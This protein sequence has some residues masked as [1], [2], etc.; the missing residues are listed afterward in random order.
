MP[1]QTL[2]CCEPNCQTPDFVFSESEQ[3]FFAEKGY[4]PPRRCPACRKA[5]REQRQVQ[6]V[7][8]APPGTNTP[9]SDAVVDAFRSQFKGRRSD[10]G[11]GDENR[12]NSWEQNEGR[13]GRGRQRRRRG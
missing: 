12:G 11:G 3:R 1:D 9:A 8:A 5:R 10:G 13:E 7:N 2:K 6:A 4:T